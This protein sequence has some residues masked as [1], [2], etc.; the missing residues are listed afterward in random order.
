MMMTK[1]VLRTQTLTVTVYC[2]DADDDHEPNDHDP[3]TMKTMAMMVATTF[4][5]AAR[6]LT[7][8]AL[9]SP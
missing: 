3:M 4:A 1:P 7:A 9:P 5:P 2:S 6:S 8:K